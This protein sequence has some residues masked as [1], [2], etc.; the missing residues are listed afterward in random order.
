MH[1]EGFKGS[2]L[3]RSQEASRERDQFVVRDSESVGWH[4]VRM[5]MEN[6]TNSW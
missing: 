5:Q 2:G 6:A 1:V 3:A 4:G